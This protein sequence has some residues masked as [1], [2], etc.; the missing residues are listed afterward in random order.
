MYIVEKSQV[1]LFEGATNKLTSEASMMGFA[2]GVWPE[3]V[4]VVDENGEGFMF[5][6]G[7]VI[8]HGEEFGGYYYYTKSGLQL[9]IFND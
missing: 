6:K 1:E 8:L 3:L 2:P 7:D 9:T 5:Q 4:G